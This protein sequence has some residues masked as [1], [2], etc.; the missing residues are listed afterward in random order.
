MVLER[1]AVR[2]GDSVL[3]VCSPRREPLARVV[4]D[5]ARLLTQTVTTHA[6]AGGSRD[7]EEPPREVAAA[8]LDASVVILLTRHSLSHT[9]A[10]LMATGHGARIAS[11]PGITEELFAS[12]I[13]VNY[14]QLALAGRALAQALTAAERCHVTSP[15]G[16]DVRLSLRGRSGISDDGALADRGAFGNLP[17]GE[18]YVA[19][20][21]F[22]AEGTIVLDGSLSGW[23]RIER[24]VTVRLDHGR[25]REISGG[26]AAAWL[27]RTLDA[28][29]VTGRTIAELGIG[30]NPAA[31][32]TGNMLGDEKALGTIHFAFGTNTSIGG[33][34]QS[35]VH[36]D[37][38]VRHP[39]LMLDDR[40]LIQRGRTVAGPD[41]WLSQRPTSP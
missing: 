8:M 37:G 36:I 25:A 20:V 26:E 33:A 27:A 24:S 12:A 31:T 41:G 15:N 13:A 40:L 22:G 6:F 21:E 29:G 19:P 10:R 14:E 1:L 3:V 18:A 9:R 23:G 28:G 5:R 4:G 30:T 38:L 16:T 34:N 35:A 39:T 2:T 17:A 7:G 32:I 11:L